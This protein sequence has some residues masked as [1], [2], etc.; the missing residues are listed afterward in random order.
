VPDATE[1]HGARNRVAAVS[2]KA[3]ICAD[4]AG[5][6]GP[7]TGHPANNDAKMLCVPDGYYGQRGLYPNLFH[8]DPK[9]IT[10]T[11]EENHRLRRILSRSRKIRRAATQLCRP[12]HRSLEGDTLVV[13]TSGCASAMATRSSGVISS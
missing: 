6:A 11:N 9:Q 4:S 7:E 13:H 8:P 12:F 2:S 3:D 10:R 5:H 1:W